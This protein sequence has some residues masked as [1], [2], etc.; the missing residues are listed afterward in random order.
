MTTPPAERMRE[1]RKRRRESHLPEVRMTL[2]D[3]R[4]RQVRERIA[5]T[6]A[7]L[8]PAAEDQALRWYFAVAT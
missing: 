5:D 7:R 4:L 8:D 6:I 2:P 3:A 1:Y